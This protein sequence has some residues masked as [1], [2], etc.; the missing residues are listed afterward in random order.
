LVADSAIYSEENLKLLEKICLDHSCP[1][2]VGRKGFDLSRTGNDTC[3]GSTLC[4]PYYFSDYGGIPQ[5]AAVF[6]VPGDADAK[7]EDL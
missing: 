4:V 7:G 3:N 5:K 1:E 6:L 2:T